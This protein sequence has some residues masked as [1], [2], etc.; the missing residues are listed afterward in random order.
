MR[1]NV[2]NNFVE[3]ISTK[4]EL[5]KLLDQ[6]KG[7]LN[8]AIISYLD[9]LIEL[10]FSVVREYI[11]P[12]DRAALSNLDVYNKIAIYNIFNRAINLFNNLYRQFEVS[13]VTDRV[14]VYMNVNNKG[15]E[16]K[17]FDF[18][19]YYA[20]SVTI[21]GYP[22]TPNLE[23][24]IS[25]YRTIESKEQIAVEIDRVT[26][27]L[28][29]LNQEQNPY[30]PPLEMGIFRPYGG[31]YDQWNSRHDY[32]KSYLENKISELESKSKRELTDDDKR[33]IELTAQ[34]NDMFLE[35]YGIDKN[36]FDRFD[37]VVANEN[38]LQK[39]LVIKRKP[40]LT[41]ENHIAYM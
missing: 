24:Q 15:R 25:L 12:E 34:I 38:Q 36:I 41:I 27:E 7:I 10:E 17:V 37:R 21:N 20:N 29:K 1:I 4:E 31:A 22:Q 6:Y 19:T 14:S 2:D 5:K 16:V 35:D 11:D 30:S 40:N 13:E 3:K 33:E 18:G 26:K 23:E 39:T 32:Q 9:A 8:D 28:E